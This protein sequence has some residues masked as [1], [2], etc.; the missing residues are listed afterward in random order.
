[1]LIDRIEPIIYN[2][3][4][5]I[6]WKD[7]IPKGIG[8]VSWSWTDSEGQPHTKKLKILLYFTES[9]VH[10]LSA[11]ALAE[12]MKQDEGTWVLKIIIFLYLELWEVQKG[13]SS[14][15]NMYLHN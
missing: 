5:S 10:T 1:M 4:A 6:G 9:L 8:M 7:L 15:R 13:N 11:S 2:A 12:S 3:V 14:L